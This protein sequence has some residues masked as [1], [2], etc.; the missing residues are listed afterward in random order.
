M[1]ALT[2]TGDLMGRLE[3]AVDIVLLK[4]CRF[5]EKILREAEVWMT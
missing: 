4:R 3:R 1:S 5:R 2:L